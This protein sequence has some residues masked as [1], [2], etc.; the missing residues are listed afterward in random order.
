MSVRDLQPISSGVRVR[1]HLAIARLDHSIKNLFVL[2][3]VIVP[4]STYPELLT[5]HLWVTLPL[6]LVS[7]TLVA[8]SNTSSTRC[9]MRLMTGCIRS[10]SIVRRRLASCMSE[11]LIPSGW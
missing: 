9:W 2:P 6:A 11:R 8:C 4:L 1:A 5:P 7:I 10:R 3:G